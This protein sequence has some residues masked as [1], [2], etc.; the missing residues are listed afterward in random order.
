MKIIHKFYFYRHYKRM[1]FI[2]PDPKYFF[3]GA[4]ICFPI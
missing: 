4:S 3:K 1:V 2:F